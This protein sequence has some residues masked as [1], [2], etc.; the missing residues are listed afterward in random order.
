M[1]SREWKAKGGHVVEGKVM[2]VEGGEVSLERAEGQVVKVKLE[3]FVEE[4]Q[5]AIREH[6]GLPDGPVPAA[7]SGA[8]AAEGLPFPMGKV[9]GPVDA[10][11]SNYFV[12]VPKSLKE[13][14]EAPLLFYTN[15][16][17]GQGKMIQELTPAAETLGWVL[18]ISVESSNK[19]GMAA[20]ERHNQACLDHLLKNLPID[21]GRLHY[22]GNSGGGS[23]AFANSSIKKAF[24]VMPNIAYIPDV[25]L[26]KTE[27]VYGLGGGSDFNRYLTAF[28]AAKYKDKGF[29]RMTNKGHAAAPPEH[30]FDGMFW[31]HCHFLADAKSGYDDE[32]RDFELATLTWLRG[33]KPNRAYSNA[34]LFRDI[35]K[36]DGQNR[37][38]LDHM[39]KKLEKDSANPLY[40]EG[41]MAISEFS[42]KYFAPLGERG[43]SK[44][45]FKDPKNAALV[46]RELMPKYGKVPELA[47]VLQAMRAQ[48]ARLTK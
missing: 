46:D 32:R 2:T 4:D 39:L 1:A 42:K 23:E 41:L 5:K 27:V 33:L 30:R 20:N 21:K 31:M 38:V 29:H 36:P 28:A 15:A 13:G 17:G 12:Y 8:K 44:I 7:G 48:T 43:G 19:R 9:H 45:G 10:G 26:E 37:Q 3:L 35:Y 22:T 16:G 34:V 24:G 25:G 47:P 14:R 6:F 11:G 40:H 18:A